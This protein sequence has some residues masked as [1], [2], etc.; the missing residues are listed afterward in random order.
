MILLIKVECMYARSIVCSANLPLCFPVIRIIPVK[1][2]QSKRF[3]LMDSFNDI[4]SRNQP[5][6]TYIKLFFFYSSLL[7]S[8]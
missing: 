3:A 8:L 5:P 7:Y 6:T 4:Y 1:K 2:S